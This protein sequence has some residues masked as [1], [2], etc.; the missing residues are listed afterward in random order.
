MYR[1][2]REESVDMQHTLTLVPRH[3]LRANFT[4]KSNNQN[5]LALGPWHAA[6][7]SD[8][9][10]VALETITKCVVYVTQ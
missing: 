1:A 7:I 10:N 4:H 2:P 8:L 5:P 9:A 6:H 3:D